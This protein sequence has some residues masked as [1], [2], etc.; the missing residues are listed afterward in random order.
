[1]LPQF[2]DEDDPR[3][4]GLSPDDVPPVRIPRP[5]AGPRPLRM[6]TTEEPGLRDRLASNLPMGDPDRGSVPPAMGGG[7]TMMPVGTSPSAPGAG[8]LGAP[9]DNPAGKLMPVGGPDTGLGSR[10]TSK[11]FIAKPGGQKPLSIAASLNNGTDNALALK[12]QRDLASWNAAESTPGKVWS[13]PEAGGIKNPIL[14]WMARVGDVAGSAMFPGVTAM[15]PETK[16][17]HKLDVIGKE[18]QYKADVNAADVQ[19]Q[20][21]ERNASTDAKLNPNPTTEFEL[22]RNQNPYSPVEDFVKLQHSQDTGKTGEDLTLHDLMTGENGKPRVNPQTGQPYT[23]LEAFNQLHQP[24][25]DTATQNKE[26]FQHSIGVLRGEGLLKA[27]DVTDFKKIAAAVEKS[28]QLSAG[29][30]DAMVGYRER[31]PPQAP[32]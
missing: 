18:N 6:Q 24:K 32:T 16:Y 28:K 11:P 10:D 5:G 15:I 3:F 2:D 25:P 27:G 7:G 26:T 9:P 8:P 1:M 17:G 20:T 22:W 19:S 4:P 12:T 21:A 13:K 14:R 23:Y 30:K 31:I 29:E